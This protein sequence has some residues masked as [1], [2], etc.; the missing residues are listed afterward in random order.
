MSGIGEDEINN[1]NLV[2][3]PISLMPKGEKIEL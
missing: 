1:N 2:K 3:S